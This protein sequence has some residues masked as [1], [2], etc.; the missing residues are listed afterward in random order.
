MPQGTA[1]DVGTIWW[2]IVDNG[3]G[4]L[5]RF[6]HRKF[7]KIR[8]GATVTFTDDD[9]DGIAENVQPAAAIARYLARVAPAGALDDEKEEQVL[10]TIMVELHKAHAEAGA[11]RQKRLRRLRATLNRF[12]R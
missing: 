7:D 9:G 1:K 12:D 10:L 11:E 8:N 4:E 2:Q 5:A 3:D 6:D